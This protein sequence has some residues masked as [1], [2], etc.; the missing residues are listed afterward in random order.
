MR[1]GPGRL[2]HER[3]PVHAAQVPGH[4]APLHHEAAYGRVNPFNP[5][6]PNKSSRTCATYYNTETGAPYDGSP[7]WH[8]LIAPA[9]RAIPPT[10]EP[11]I[12]RA[13]TFPALPGAPLH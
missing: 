10:P 6:L 11:A 4:L 7:N 8:S 3:Q 1:L 12:A 13:R 9:P 2:G 5:C